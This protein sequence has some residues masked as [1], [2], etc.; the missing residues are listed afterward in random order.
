MTTPSLQ[1]TSPATPTTRELIDLAHQHGIRVWWRSRNGGRAHWS[2]DYRSV[3]LA[4]DLT[5]CEARSLL[6]HELGHAHY[7]DRGPQRPDRETRAWR[8]A[9][10]LLV[11]DDEYAAAEALHDQ[12]VAAIADDLHVTVEVIHAHQ[13]TLRRTA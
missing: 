10:W 12:D 1:G 4:P 5:D 8:Y 9:A 7:G 2:A 3:W 13:T 11:A 6:A